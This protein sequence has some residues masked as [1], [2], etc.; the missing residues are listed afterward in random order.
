MNEGGRPHRSS[1]DTRRGADLR[2]VVSLLVLKLGLA[3]CQRQVPYPTREVR[4][5][6]FGSARI[7]VAADDCPAFSFSV[8]P[9]GARIGGQIRAVARASDTDPL[10]RLTYNWTSSA[11]LLSA[12]DA[13]ETTYTCPGRDRAGPQTLSLTVSDGSCATTQAVS[14]F[15]YVLADGGGP[16][17]IGGGGGTSGDAGVS[18]DSALATT[19]EGDACNTCTDDNCET[20]ASSARTGVAPTA[21][22]DIF[23][24]PEKQSLC[25]K[26]YA[27]LRD[28][29]CVKNSDPSGCWCGSLDPERCA[30]GPALGDGPCLQQA[31]D[32]AGSNVPAIIDLRA[33]DPSFA[34]GGAVN[35]ATCRSIY[36]S[37]LSDTPTATPAC[38]L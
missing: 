1:R 22:C 7:A 20:L 8:S 10:S 3:G 33:T 27:C 14:V 23:A 5:A 6:G 2:G 16:A 13:A 37:R 38:L 15:C 28:S 12:A 18:C 21:G 31:I 36:C 4:D 35:L 11:G 30:S 25:Q 26:L 19:C 24:S 17:T 34:I 9:A 29:G 32:A